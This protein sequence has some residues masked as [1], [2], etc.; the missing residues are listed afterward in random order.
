MIALNIS[1]EQLIDAVNGLTATEKEQLSEVLG[2][3]D[4]NLSAEQKELI[5]QRHQQYVSGAKTYSADEA[6]AML[7]YTGR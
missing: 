5:W 3:A 2:A 7:N 4:I 1:I 6:K